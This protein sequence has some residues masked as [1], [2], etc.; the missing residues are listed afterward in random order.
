MP[1][2]AAPI[3]AP[4]NGQGG[5]PATTTVPPAEGTNPN[6]VTPSNQVN[7]N[8]MTDNVAP[9]GQIVTGASS[10]GAAAA[11]LAPATGTG[12][13]SGVVVKQ[14]MGQAGTGVVSQT[15]NVASASQITQV[16]APANNPQ[17]QMQQQQQQMGGNQAQQAGGVAQGQQA[18][19]SRWQ[20]DAYLPQRRQM[21]IHIVKLLQ[22]RKPGGWVWKVF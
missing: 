8:T 4:Q 7:N 15:P 20:N 10:T 5:N 11:S 17:Q 1:E 13:M 9:A 22:K 12:A 6:T 19:V 14:E 3:S 16:T 2:V 21:V 18:A